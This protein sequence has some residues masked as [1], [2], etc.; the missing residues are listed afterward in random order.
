MEK[1]GLDEVL[2]DKG[3]QITIGHIVNVEREN[4]N[5]RTNTMYWLFPMY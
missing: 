5:K 4:V 3:E 2:S 1:E